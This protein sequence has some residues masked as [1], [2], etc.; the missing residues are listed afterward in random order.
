MPGEKGGI[1]LPGLPVCFCVPIKIN[2]QK[3]IILLAAVSSN[4]SYHLL[5]LK[6]LR[7]YWLINVSGAYNK[8]KAPKQMNY[9]INLHVSLNSFY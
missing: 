1:G 6:Y 3:R 7:Y 4:Q 8:F 2:N 9:E 5:I